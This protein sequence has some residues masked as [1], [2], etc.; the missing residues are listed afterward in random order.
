M[1]STGYEGFGSTLSSRKVNFRTMLK[2]AVIC[3]MGPTA[4]GKTEL[5][6][7]LAD[8]INCELISVDSVQIYRGLD[9]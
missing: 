6:I 5:A 8:H 1:D 4:A 9:I 3:L 7:N 2:P